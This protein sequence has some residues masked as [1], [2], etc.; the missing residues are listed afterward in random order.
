MTSQPRLPVVAGI[1]L[2][3][4][5]LLQLLLAACGGGMK[6]PAAASVPAPAPSSPAAQARTLGAASPGD[7]IL[8]GGGLISRAV[9]QAIV[10]RVPPGG[11]LCVIKSALGEDQSSR[12]RFGGLGYRVVTLDPGPGEADDA[13]TVASLSGCDGFYFEGGDPERLSNIF[14]PHGR[15]TAALTAIRGRFAQ[16]AVLSGTSAGAMIVGPVTLCECGTRSSPMAL[17]RGQ[18]FQAP[19]FDFLPDVLVDAHF[20]ARGLIGRHFVALARTRAALGL[21]ID[22][23]TAVVVPGDGG[24]WAVIG[25]R[26]VAVIEPPPQARE[27]RL[28]GFTVSLLLPGD[29]F[30]FASRTVMPGPGR[31]ER[32]VSISGNEPPLRQDRIFAPDAARQLIEALALSPA[33]VAVGRYDDDVT[34]LFGKT[35]ETRV[36]ADAEGVTV[37]RLASAIRRR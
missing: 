8:E 9:T 32:Q 12:S 7:L 21:G 6:Q 16:G 4:A 22:E 28:V 24:P 30:Y 33:T 1:A 25:R 17:E 19:G 23:E 3:G 35:M 10:A 2:A 11:T 15:D 13:G 14:R 37:V 26:A 31:S 34:V 5:M 18:L 20:F 29:R 36:F 27:E